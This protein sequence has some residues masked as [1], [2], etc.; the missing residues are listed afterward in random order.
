MKLILA[1]LALIFTGSLAQAH[2]HSPGMTHLV[3]ANGTVHAHCTWTQGP[4][5][6]DESLLTIE[7]MNGTTHTPAEPPGT[8]TVALF[9]PKMGHGSAPTQAQRVLDKDGHAVEGAY[10]ISNIYF[11]MGGKWQVNVTLKYA[12][13]TEETKTID[14]DL[15]QQNGGGHHH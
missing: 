7:W 8:F 5:T 3:F 4:Q 15:G 13:G 14:V 6:P 2:D 11:T 12:D 10:A 1:S 9:M